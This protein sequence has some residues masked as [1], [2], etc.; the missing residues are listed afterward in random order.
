MSVAFSKQAVSSSRNLLG[1]F[2]SELSKT[3]GNCKIKA[4]TSTGVAYL[5]SR[6]VHVLV[7][8]VE[9]I[10]QQCVPQHHLWA[11]KS[12]SGASQVMQW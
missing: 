6:L 9:T 11:Y 4:G 1:E 5:L 10:T 3:E 12:Q 8:K 7:I 2:Q